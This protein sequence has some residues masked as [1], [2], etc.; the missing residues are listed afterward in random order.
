MHYKKK[1]REKISTGSF[2]LKKSTLAIL[3]C[4]SDFEQQSRNNIVERAILFEVCNDWKKSKKAY[5][6][7]KK[8]KKVFASQRSFKKFLQASQAKTF[9]QECLFGEH[10]GAK[11]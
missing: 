10:F 1:N 11:L 7:P 2:F 9:E 8:A 3:E 5:K 4:I 6:K